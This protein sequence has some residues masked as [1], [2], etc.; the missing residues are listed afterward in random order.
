MNDHWYVVQKLHVAQPYCTLHSSFSLKL[1][2]LAWWGGP[3][4]SQLV[5]QSRHVW[6]VAK[7]NMN[8]KRKQYS[9]AGSVKKDYG[10]GTD[11]GQ[12]ASSSSEM[13][14]GNLWRD[15]QLKVRVSQM[16]CK[17]NY[18]Q[19]NLSSGGDPEVLAKIMP[20]AI[21]TSGPWLVQW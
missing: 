20:S 9:L 11:M 18:L 7:T 19:T 12:N 21:L 17:H 4:S 5:V 13:G 10:Y 8:R 14:R 2:T 15:S 3:N 6:T 16:S 1:V